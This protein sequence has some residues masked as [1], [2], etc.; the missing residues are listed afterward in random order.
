MRGSFPNLK[1][2][3]LKHMPDVNQ[4]VVAGG[5]LPVI[6]GLYIVS[7][8]ELE[9]VPQGIET[10]CSLKKLWLLNLHKYFKSHWTDGEMHQKMQHVPDL[11]V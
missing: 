1:T 7:L 5:A 3:V 8:P 6:E 4:L 9:R 10:L 11:R 2:M